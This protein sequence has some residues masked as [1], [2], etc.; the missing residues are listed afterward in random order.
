LRAEAAAEDLTIEIR[1]LDVCDNASVVAALRDAADIDVLI[2]NAGFEVQTAVELLDE[3]LFFRQLDT[4]VHGPVRLIRTV[5]PTWRQ[6]GNGTIV[7]VSSIAGLV[8]APYGGAYSASKFALEALSEALHFEVGQ[9]GI[10]VKLIEPGRFE[11]GF[12]DN[13][14]TPDGW[15]SSFYYDRSNR[16]RDA[17]GQL[18]GGGPEPDPQD[19]ADAI[20]AAATDPTTPFRTLVGADAQ[21]IAGVKGSLS[22]EEFEQTMRQTLDWQD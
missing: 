5:L 9:L 4:N 19:V 10:H 21:L 8:G 2:N 22:F 3:A 17:L 15:E 13:I 11:T 6:R 7:N 18:G 14:V 1:Q 12:H 20:V 16:F